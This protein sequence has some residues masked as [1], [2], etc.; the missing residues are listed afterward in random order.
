MRLVTRRAGSK[1]VQSN[2]ID[3]EEEPLHWTTR[4]NSVAFS[5]IGEGENVAA[6]SKSGSVKA[7]SIEEMKPEVSNKDDS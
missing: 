7:E 5:I 3:T 4:P 6:R 1:T 2:R